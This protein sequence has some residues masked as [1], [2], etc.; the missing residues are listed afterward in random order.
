MPRIRAESIAAHKEASRAAILDA[1]Q[2]VFL[3][4][5]YS[6]GS[7][8]AIADV[9]GIPRTTI[10]EYFHSKGDILLA[11]VEDRVPPLLNGILEAVDD[12]PPLEAINHIFVRA[13]DLVTKSP[14]LAELMF[15]V[16]RELPKTLR[17]RMWE[18]FSPITS[19]LYLECRAGSNAGIFPSKH[20]D[21]CGRV[22]ADML[23]SA[24]DEL[25]QED[26]PK[27]V[28]PIIVASRLAFIRGGLLGS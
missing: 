19:R 15:R 5:G 23:V 20:P 13:I 25:T 22:L 11:V 21:R 1:A 10:Y 9:S 3:A 24:I 6:G 26:D 8:T 28:A 2:K 4:N 16:G 7:L 18:L 12:D 17:D 14:E 27:K